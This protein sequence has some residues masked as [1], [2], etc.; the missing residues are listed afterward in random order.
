MRATYIHNHPV[1]LA[2][3]LPDGYLSMDHQIR[4]ILSAKPAVMAYGEHNIYNPSSSL[5]NIQF[6]ETLQHGLHGVIVLGPYRVTQAPSAQTTDQTVVSQLSPPSLETYTR[7][8][9]GL[10]AQPPIH[11]MQLLPVTSTANT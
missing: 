3:R 5:L 8:N 9:S 6:Q 7:R 10:Q 2:A 1:L 11:A 4:S